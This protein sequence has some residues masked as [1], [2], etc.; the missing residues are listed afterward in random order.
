MCIENKVECIVIDE[1]KAYIF[2]IDINFFEL[3]EVKWLPSSIVKKL[4]SY[5][6]YNDRRRMIG[7]IMTY[8]YGMLILVY[9]RDIL[10]LEKDLETILRWKYNIYGKPFVG[11]EFNFNISH[12]GKYAL[13][14]FSKNEIG[15]DI[16]SI[17][18]DY[19]NI[20]LE[21]F[22]KNEAL[23]IMMEKKDYQAAL[24][25]E[26]WVRKESFIKT[27]GK[28]LNMDLASFSFES[29]S[30][31]LWKV[32]HSIDCSKYLVKDIDIADKD[33]RMAVCCKLDNNDSYIERQ[34]I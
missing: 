15:V 33:Y 10:K 32:K 13:C 24:F 3:R 6:Y 21:F 25:T 20:A 5:I 17:N 18:P 2:Y 31:N 4:N 1:M 12:S 19:V 7:G 34:I 14:G 28:G 9:N 27:V 8:L 16:E 11:K 30:N 22:T 26:L 23:M 29:I